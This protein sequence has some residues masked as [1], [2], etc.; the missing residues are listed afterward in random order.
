[1]DISNISR[2][3]CPH[4]SRRFK[5]ISECSWLLGAKKI[6]G[7]KPGG[8]AFLFDSPRSELDRLWVGITGLIEDCEE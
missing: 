6:A 3:R 2:R 7:N 1:M 8:E 5:V 4:Q